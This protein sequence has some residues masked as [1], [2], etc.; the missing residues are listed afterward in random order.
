MFK[1]L[2]KVQVTQSDI[3][4]GVIRNCTHCPVALALARETGRAARV[5]R[6]TA[7]IMDVK[8]SDGVPLDFA[9]SRDTSEWITEFDGS[10]GRLTPPPFTAVVGVEVF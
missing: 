7:A 5:G 6:F 8:G 1:P 4:A 10:R 3:D 2:F 9:L